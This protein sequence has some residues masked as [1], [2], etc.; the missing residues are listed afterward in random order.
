MNIK[1]KNKKN[2]EKNDINIKS[3]IKIYIG[4]SARVILFSS[5]FLVLLF[6]SI[7]L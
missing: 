7:F 4:Y 5:I 2:T 1:L 3:H 6:I